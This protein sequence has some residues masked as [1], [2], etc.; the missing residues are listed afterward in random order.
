[1]SEVI[2]FAVVVDG[3]VAGT[4]GFDSSANPS[5]MER[6]VAALR[7]P[8]QIVE[9]PTVDVAHGWTYDGSEFHPPV[10]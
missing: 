5:T 6:M 8:H 9:S 4:L 3:E 7:S 2:K 1:M 10:K